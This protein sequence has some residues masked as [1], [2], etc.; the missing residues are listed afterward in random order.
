MKAL[1]TDIKNL[2]NTRKKIEAGE[3]ILQEA[4]D[5]FFK[6]NLESLSEQKDPEEMETV[7]I[8]WQRAIERGYDPTET[9]AEYGHV[10]RQYDLMI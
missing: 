3:K 10:F 6:T 4:G 9:K 8:L 1:E 5:F 7:C 2:Y